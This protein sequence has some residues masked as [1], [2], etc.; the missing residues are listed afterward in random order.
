VFSLVPYAEE[1][2]QRYVD[3]RERQAQASRVFTPEQ[4]E[5]LDRIAEHVATSLT[6]EPADFEDGWFGQ[7]GSLRRAHGL[8]GAQL[9]PLLTELNE[10]L[11][12]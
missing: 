6:I 11:A 10:W 5:W 1:V 8:F 4:S 12:A 3:W 2:R 9:Q 7:Q